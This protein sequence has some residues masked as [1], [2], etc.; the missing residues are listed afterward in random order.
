MHI[1]NLKVDKKYPK[2]FTTVSVLG[3]KENRQTVEINLPETEGE[4]TYGIEVN[5]RVVIEETKDAILV[6]KGSVYQLNSNNYVKILENGKP[7]ERE[8]T[9]G[10]EMNDQVEVKAGLTEG[11]LVIL[12][13][14]DN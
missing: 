8:I 10:L 2:A 1:D 4:F 9:I 7:V 14:Q 13:Y 5:T 12:N 3:E 6:P 11:D